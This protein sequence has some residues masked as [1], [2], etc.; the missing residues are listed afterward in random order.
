M[1][2]AF[3]IPP[4]AS[5]RVF[6]CIDPGE[7]IPVVFVHGLL[8]SA[9]VWT[10]PHGNG[11]ALFQAVASLPGFVADVFDY[12]RFSDRWVTHESIAPALAG[13]I[14]CLA[15][16][17][18]RG[19]GPGRVVVVGHSM[20]GLAIRQ[21]LG[22]KGVGEAVG[23]AVTI[24]SPHKGSGMARLAYPGS[25]PVYGVVGRP[26]ERLVWSL[27]GAV[28]ALPGELLPGAALE[29]RSLCGLLRYADTEAGPAMVKGSAELAALPQFPPALPVRAVAAQLPVSVP[30]LWPVTVRMGDFVVGVDSATNGHA[31]RGRYEDRGG[32]EF[33]RICEPVGLGSLLTL[34]L[35]ETTEIPCEHRG[36]LRDLDVIADV[37]GSLKRWAEAEVMAS[38]RV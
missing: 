1:A 24:A 10:S 36:V 21:A 13:R 34:A 23:L 28:C 8:G 26:G 2:L 3:G 11:T 32:G 14:K 37:T 7:R 9:D 18:H 19:Y 29:D 6:D 20:G 16:A 4:G 15:E 22:E 12:G 33:V 35:E 17:S 38:G 5:A 27:L 31:F 25:G 30:F